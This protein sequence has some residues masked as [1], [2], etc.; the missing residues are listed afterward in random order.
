MRLIYH[1]SAEA[2]LIEVAQFY[3]DRVPQLGL[4]FL[5]A[6]DRA[7]SVILQAPERCRMKTLPL[8][9]PLALASGG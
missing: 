4:Q 9:S 6:S 5:E 8:Q 1:P 3:E 2:E 7:L